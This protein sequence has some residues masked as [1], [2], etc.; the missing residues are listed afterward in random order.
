MDGGKKVGLGTEMQGED[1]RK[2]VR[3]TGLGALSVNYLGAS[4]CGIL[5]VPPTPG[6]RT[7]WKLPVKS[8]S[9]ENFLQPLEAVTALQVVQ[10]R[11]WSIER[12]RDS[13]QIIY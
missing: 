10:T 9:S 12:L 8:I 1:H 6:N 4:P 2:K 5:L 11:G 13:P 3:R 7:D